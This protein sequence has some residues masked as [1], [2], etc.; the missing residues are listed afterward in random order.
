MSGSI[1]VLDLHAPVGKHDHV[2]IVLN[3]KTVIR[4]NDP[5][6]FGCCLFAEP[7]IEEHRLIAKLGPEPLGASFDGDV[8]FEQS[9]NRSIAIKNLIMDAKVVVGVGNIYAC[10][11][12]FMAKIR[13]TLS[14]KRLSRKRCH[15]LAKA[16]KT[17]L[18]NAIKAGGTTLNDFSQ[19]DGKPGYFAQKLQV[20]GMAGK[21]CESCHSEIKSLFIGQR[22]THYCPKCQTF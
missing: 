12:L 2:D 17:V 14:A 7:P 13:P 6:R 22:N 15:S 21:P 8:L 3:H 20:Y 1:R 10:E 4:L 16:I 5:R 9:R 11:S 18:A 19:T